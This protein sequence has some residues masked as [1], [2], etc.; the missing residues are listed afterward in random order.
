MNGGIINSITRLDLVGYFSWVILRCTD[1][2]ILNKCVGMYLLRRVECKQNGVLTQLC[3]QNQC[4]LLLQNLSSIQAVFSNA[5]Y[6][7]LVIVIGTD[8]V[9][10]LFVYTLTRLY[11]YTV[12]VQLVCNVFSI[13]M[14]H[15]MCIY[16]RIHKINIY[17]Y[18]ENLLSYS[19][20][21]FCGFVL[22]HCKLTRYS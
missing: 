13:L 3:P 15:V 18:S 9:L 22:K 4:A 21:K 2:W 17:Q 16:T 6:H 14:T 20:I 1:P 19:I 8:A 10:Y 7:I 12:W 11:F 5:A